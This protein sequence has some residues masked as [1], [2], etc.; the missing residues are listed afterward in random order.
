MRLDDEATIIFKLG[1]DEHGISWQV[2]CGRPHSTTLS[3]APPFLPKS[4]SDDKLKI[5]PI[6]KYHIGTYVVG[7]KQ[8]RNSESYFNSF[9][10]VV[11]HKLNEINSEMIPYFYP[12]LKDGSKIWGEEY[13]KTLPSLVDSAGMY[14]HVSKI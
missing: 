2:K 8:V 10:I 14:V 7:V 5:A 13:L 3:N 4:L 11:D 1:S 12:E 6:E 9:I